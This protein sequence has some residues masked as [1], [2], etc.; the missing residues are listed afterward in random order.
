M[1]EFNWPWVLLLVPLPA[2]VYW[3]TPPA[4]QQQ[5]AIRVPFYQSLASATDAHQQN[6]QT[7]WLQQLLVILIWLLLLT[8]LAQPRWVGKPIS[9]PTSSRELMLAVDLSGSMEHQDLKL[10]GKQVDRLTV[11]KGVLQDFIARRKGD[12][13]GL[14]LFGSQAYLQAPMTYDLNT[15]TTL[16]DEALIGMAGKN[17]AIGDAVGLGVKQLRKRPTDSRVLILL[18]DGANTAGEVTPIQAAEL[19]A[20]EGIKIYTIGV[21]ADEMILP[22]VFGTSFGARRVNPSIDLDEKTLKAMAA[23]TQGQ[24][25]RARNSEELNKIYALLDELEPVSQQDQTFR[26]S[27]SYY[28]WPLATALLLSFSLALS[29]LWPSLSNRLTATSAKQQAHADVANLLGNK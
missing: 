22:G 1:F 2:F 27:K 3:L 20:K 12:R 28:H 6:P 15:V 11:V 21:G 25:F 18:T 9:L 8:A 4:K 10:K 29:R 16:L 19:A 7:N 24:Y 23:K 14:I 13:L 26:P 5:A 17:T